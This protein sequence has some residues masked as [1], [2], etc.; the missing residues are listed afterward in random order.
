MTLAQISEHTGLGTE[1]ARL[2]AQREF[3]EPFLLLSGDAER[4]RQAAASRG[5]QFTRGG[6]FFHVFEKGTKG[7]ALGSL[8]P[9]HDLCA[10]LGDSENDRPMLDAADIA[11]VIPGGNLEPQAGWRVAA[12]KGPRGWNEEVLRLVSEI[13]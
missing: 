3:V 2:A 8:R 4:L 10:A 13:A 12:H 1:A 6:R 11:I 7:E 5:L 9:G